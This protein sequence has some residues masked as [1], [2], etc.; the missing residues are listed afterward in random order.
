MSGLAIRVQ[1]IL[2]FVVEVYLW[3]P[4][5]V[6]HSFWSL[7]FPFIMTAVVAWASKTGVRSSMGSWD[8]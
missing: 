8:T 1:V 6:E 5:C 3:R 4:V 7:L 2:H